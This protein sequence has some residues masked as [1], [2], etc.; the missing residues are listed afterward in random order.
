M[1]QIQQQKIRIRLKAYDHHLLNTSCEKIV[2]TAERTSAITVGPIPLPTKKRI[3]CV[4]K[5]IKNNFS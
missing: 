1:T 5:S 2:N 3:Y 4:C